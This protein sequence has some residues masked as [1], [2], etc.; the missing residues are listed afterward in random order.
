MMLW[1]TWLLGLRLTS[2]ILFS[3][4]RGG[5]TEAIRRISHSVVATQARAI[6]ARES[7]SM[8]LTPGS[9]PHMLILG[10]AR[11][12]LG[13]WTAACAIRATRGVPEMVTAMARIVLDL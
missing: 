6:R 3:I 4:L 9:G 7:M 13:P 5:W 2:V 10:A 12:R 8:C 11:F 1:R